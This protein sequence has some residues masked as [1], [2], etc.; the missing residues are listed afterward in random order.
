MP[1]GFLV[2]GDFMA[3]SLADGLADAFAGG[4]RLTVVDRVNGSSGLVRTD[5]YDWNAELPA[6]L[7]EVQ[8]YAVVVMIG[9]NDRQELR[10]TTGT[11]RL[12]TA[13][14]DAAYNARAVGLTETLRGF[15]GPVFWVGEPPMRQSGMSADM[16]FFNS[17]YE[18]AIEAAGGIY[19]DIWD[20]FA[21]AD[22][23]FTATGPDVDGRTR[24]LRSSDGFSFT[25]AG[26]AK[27]AFI[28][29][30]DIRAYES[31]AGQIVVAAPA[32]PEPPT[33]PPAAGDRPA[34]GPLIAFDAPP[35]PPAPRGSSWSARR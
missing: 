4:P 7:A 27:L 6:I 31:G 22:G 5:F 30:R 35:P 9:T 32:F 21:D 15:G 11:L 33:A 20:A 28:V 16:A 12:R 23:R 26:Q 10:T 24:T 17:V 8:P 18:A 34:A 19:V 2:I 1:A 13:A 14:W 3:R 25:A 29:D